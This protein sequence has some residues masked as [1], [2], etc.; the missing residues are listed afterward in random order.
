[1][2]ISE[3][4]K[5]RCKTCDKVGEHKFC[6]LETAA[7][8]LQQPTNGNGDARDDADGVVGSDVTNLIN[9]HAATLI[10]LQQLKDIMLTAYLLK[11]IK[12][13]VLPSFFY[14]FSARS[15]ICGSQLV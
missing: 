7:S 10:Y 5:G 15:Q 14:H 13:R 8:Q 12:H 11:G 4:T 9:Q 1:M 6:Q 3:M 2:K